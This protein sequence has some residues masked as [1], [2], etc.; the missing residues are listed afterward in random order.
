[1]LHARLCVSQDHKKQRKTHTSA[2]ARTP[3]TCSRL[4][5]RKEQHWRVHGARCTGLMSSEGNLILTQRERHKTSG[6]TDRK[7]RPSRPLPREK[8]RHGRYLCCFVYYCTRKSTWSPPRPPPASSADAFKKLQ[9]SS[10]PTRVG[11][12]RTVG[13]TSSKGVLK[14]GAVKVPFGIGT[15]LFVVRSNNAVS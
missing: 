8:Y 1:M 9:T 5:K 10:S 15:P 13:T 6:R 12:R 11:G 2:V 4:E 14:K 7:E 3:L